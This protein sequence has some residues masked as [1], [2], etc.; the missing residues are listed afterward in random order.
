MMTTAPNEKKMSGRMGAGYLSPKWIQADYI[1]A[2]P[3]WET[4]LDGNRVLVLTEESF[5][6]RIEVQTPD[7]TVT[8]L[9]ARVPK[10]GREEEA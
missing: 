9:M 10:S 2:G 3:R 8:A 5:A 7:G 1:G 6:F 4:R